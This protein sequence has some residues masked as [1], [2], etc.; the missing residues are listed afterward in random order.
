MKTSIITMRPFIADKNK[1]L[2]VM[3]NYILE[4]K[5]DLYI[6]GE[7]SLTGYRCKDELRDLAEDIDGYSISYLKEL[8]I[9][10]NCY[11]VFG[12]PLRD[13]I[14]NGVLHNSAIFIH[15]SGNVDFY[16]KW[17]FPNFGP[18]EEKLFFDGGEKLNIIETKF[19]KIG[20]IICYDLFFPELCKAYSLQGANMVICL[21][22]SPSITRK[23]FEPLLPA[24]AIENTIFMIYANIVGTQED[25]VFWGGSQVYDPLGNLIIKSPYFKE[26][27]VSCDID[28][29][30]INLAR[31]N[32]PVI[33]DIRPEIFND[34]YNYSRDHK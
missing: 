4:N 32:R 7:M 23:Y 28:F 18:F 29:K 22:A 17:F 1:N 26:S 27:V 14:V 12:M 2:E 6:F 13:S 3:K 9:K 25:L 34:L 11:I 5:S 30:D 20:L 10:R 21:S 8:A 33:R 15:P 31:A 16:N 19:G 24:R